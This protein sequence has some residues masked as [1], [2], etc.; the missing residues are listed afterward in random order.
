MNKFSRIY[1]N[2]ISL[3]SKHKENILGTG[4]N[5]GYQAGYNKC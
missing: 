3:Y 5:Y 4:A 1:V 2:K